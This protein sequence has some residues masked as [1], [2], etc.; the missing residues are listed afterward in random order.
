MAESQVKRERQRYVSKTQ[1]VSVYKYSTV[2][3]LLH[4]NLHEKMNCS[5]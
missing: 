3:K 5:L 1:V 4:V 2:N